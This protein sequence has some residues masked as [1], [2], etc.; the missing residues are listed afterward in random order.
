MHLL[1]QKEGMI[2][3]GGCCGSWSDSHVTVSERS[4]SEALIQV[5][6]ANAK[7]C[8]ERQACCPL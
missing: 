5:T 4:A 7:G 1:T 2:S 6:A 3:T 8:L